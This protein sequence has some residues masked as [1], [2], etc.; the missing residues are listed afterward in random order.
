M[1][2]VPSIPHAVIMPTIHYDQ[3]EYCHGHSTCVST[4]SVHHHCR[5]NNVPYGEFALGQATIVV[6]TMPEVSRSIVVNVLRQLGTFGTVRCT[7][8]VTYSE[9]GTCDSM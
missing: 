6:E 2:E 5:A 1:G 3:L 4:C 7:V 8:A 9:V